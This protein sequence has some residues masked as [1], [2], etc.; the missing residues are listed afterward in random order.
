S[1]GVG[2]SFTAIAPVAGATR[3]VTA[4]AYPL[5]WTDS[6]YLPGASAAK[7][8]LPSEPVVVR[9]WSSGMATSASSIGDPDESVTR[10]ATRDE[11][12][13]R[14]GEVES[15]RTATTPIQ[16]ARL[17]VRSPSRPRGGR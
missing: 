11:V 10:P 7:E 15:A 3:G 1:K 6:V 13:A 17:T 8:K 5:R 2:T 4:G 9:R 16:S 14:V 12:P